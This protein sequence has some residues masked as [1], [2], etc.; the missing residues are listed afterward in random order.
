MDAAT[1]SER[2]LCI[3]NIWKARHPDAHLTVEVEPTLANVHGVGVDIAWPSSK[4][5]VGR[6][7]V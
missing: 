4:G 7:E 5:L 1:G 6:I 3:A 2:A